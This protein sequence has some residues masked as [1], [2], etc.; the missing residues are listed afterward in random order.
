MH[1]E[2]SPYETALA[3]GRADEDTTARAASRERHSL[4]RRFVDER[5]R[6]LWLKQIKDCPKRAVE[7]DFEGAEFTHQGAK[8]TLEVIL[9]AFRLDQDVALSC[10]GTLVHYLD[11]GGVP[12]AEA[13]GFA[14]IIAG[15]RALQPNDDA[16]LEAM[17]P[18]LDSFY[19]AYSQPDSA[20]P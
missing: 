17:T 5:A 19:V 3:G 1:G 11:V 12:V 16:L 4:R 2:R 15:A 9:A 18:V 6:F 14:T 13:A 8:V 20:A 10:L 7:F